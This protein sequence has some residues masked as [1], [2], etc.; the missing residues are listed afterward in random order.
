MENQSPFSSAVG[1]I[2]DPQLVSTYASPISFW[3]GINGAFNELSGAAH[4][5]NTGESKTSWEFH[6]AVRVSHEPNV[7][8]SCG[9]SQVTTVLFWLSSRFRDEDGERI[10]PG[11]HIRLIIK[12]DELCNWEENERDGA[13]SA[14][15][16]ERKRKRRN[17]GI[18][19]ETVKRG[20][21]VEPGLRHVIAT[22]LNSKSAVVRS[23]NCVRRITRHGETESTPWNQSPYACRV[24]KMKKPHFS[25]RIRTVEH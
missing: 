11:V 3:L 12:Q 9:D 5:R 19:K 22:W 23:I 24:L 4:R 14:E 21:N 18:G 15:F 8:F 20:F 2:F 25:Q 1:L 16:T 7:S 17:G 13:A 6:F 10:G